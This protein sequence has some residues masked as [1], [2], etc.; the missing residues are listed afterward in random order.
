MT[1]HSLL[2]L[3]QNKNAQA[4]IRLGLK[5][6]FKVPFFIQ[7]AMLEKT[8]LHVFREVL[9]EGELDFLIGHYLKIHIN[10]MNCTWY[11][12]NIKQKIVVQKEAQAT[13]AI[14]GKLRSFAQL[15]AHCTDPDTLFFQRKLMIEGNTEM[16][17]QIKNLLDDIDPETL[18]THLNKIIEMT[19]KY[20]C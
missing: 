2:H 6:V 5:G 10:D 12:T 1:T 8:L 17:L 18:P 13:I 20:I 4:I 11:F 15:T 7:K 9:H 14:S 19:S 16:G 3:S